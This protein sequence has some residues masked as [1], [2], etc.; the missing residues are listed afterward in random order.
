MNELGGARVGGRE[1]KRAS[2]SRKRTKAGMSLKRKDMQIC[3]RPIK[4]FGEGGGSRFRAEGRWPNKPKRPKLSCSKQIQEF[5]RKQT[6]ASYLPCSLSVTAKIGPLFGKFKCGRSIKDSV[7]KHNRR[8]PKN[9]VCATRC[10][11]QKPVAR[12]PRSEDNR[13][14]WERRGPGTGSRRLS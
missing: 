8:R 4:V 13:M 14:R 9:R 2:G 5:R 1:T 7:L 6:Q 12:P 11:K 10:Q 3:D